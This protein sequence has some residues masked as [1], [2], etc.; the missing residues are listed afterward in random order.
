MRQP[1][2]NSSGI[3][4]AVARKTSKRRI[5]RAGWLSYIVHRHAGPPG[6][7][8]SPQNG[9]QR[10]AAEHLDVR[11]WNAISRFEASNCQPL[12]VNAIASAFPSGFLC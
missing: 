10:D 12:A 3:K 9:M 5:F 8:S 1:P 6:R 4:H 7:R 11:P 2:P